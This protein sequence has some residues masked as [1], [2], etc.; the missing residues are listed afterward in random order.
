MNEQL[1]QEFLCVWG[2]EGEEEGADCGKGGRHS[3]LLQ[4]RGE[5]VMVV[6]VMW[7]P[8]PRLV[9]PCVKSGDVLRE[10]SEVWM[11][12]EGPWFSWSRAT[13]LLSVFPA[14]P[15]ASPTV[16]P[17]VRPSHRH[18]RTS[19]R[20]IDLPTAFVQSFLASVRPSFRP[21][22]G[23]SVRASRLL[24]VLSD[25][26]TVRPLGVGPFVHPPVR[27]PQRPPARPSEPL[28]DPDQLTTRPL[29]PS[30]ICPHVPSTVRPSV[31]P[32]FPT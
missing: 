28:T 26:P 11:E 29:A 9:A 10:V 12:G 22:V 30:S 3:L 15:P 24:R 16:H 7:Q 8:A 6:M 25:G 31:R 32:S 1:R 4:A 23:T 17:A 27:L 20:T 13:R 21:S 18:A 5:V 14:R 19:V 2:G